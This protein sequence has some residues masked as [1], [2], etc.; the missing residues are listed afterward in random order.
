[1]GEGDEIVAKVAARAAD[2]RRRADMDTPPTPVP[3]ADPALL[4]RIEAELGFRLP[5]LLKRLY[6]EV[7][8]GCFGPG[9][10]LFGATGH[11]LS[12]EPF[13]LAELYRINHKGDWP[14]GLVPICDWGCAIWS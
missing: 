9:Y 10:G 7:G 13:T 11:W 1:M 2:P 6:L 3:L 8:D 14:D 5:S 12:D 4:Q